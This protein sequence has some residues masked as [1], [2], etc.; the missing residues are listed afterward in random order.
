LKSVLSPTYPPFNTA[1]IPDQYRAQIFLQEFNNYEKNHNLP[2]LSV[3]TLPQDHTVGTGMPTPNAMVA[4]ND[5]AL[6][7]IVDAI[8]HSP[9]W[10]DSAIFVTEDDAQNGLDHVDGHRTTGF[11]ISPYTKPGVVSTTYTQIDMVRTIEQILGMPAMNQADL[12]ASPMFDAFTNKLNFA[13][14]TALPNWVPL[15][16]L[17]P[18]PAATSAPA[19][20]GSTQ[21]NAETAKLAWAQWSD[22]AFSGTNKADQQDSN[23]LNRAIW[24]QGIQH[25]VPLRQLWPANAADPK[26]RR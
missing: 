21:S 6:G 22:Q 26:R 12:A 23:L 15:N 24:S 17:A 19:P 16:Q 9:D 1:S 7:K 3:L 20:T 18:A 25:G 4:N 8:S 13:P 14:F 5:L 2:N 10:K 11:V